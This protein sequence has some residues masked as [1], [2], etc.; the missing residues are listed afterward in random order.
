M[1]SKVDFNT[2]YNIPTLLSQIAST[3]NKLQRGDEEARKACLTAARDLQF[4]LEKP[5]E[6]ILRTRVS[7]V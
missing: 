5:T 4:A 3:S 6:S 7:E 2:P 1:S